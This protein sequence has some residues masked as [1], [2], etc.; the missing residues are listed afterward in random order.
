MLLML[1]CY[2]LVAMQEARQLFESPEV[3]DPESLKVCRVLGG[4]MSQAGN[5]SWVV[6]ACMQNTSYLQGRF[7]A[8][9]GSSE[10]TEFT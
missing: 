7:D 10:S 3:I 5:L 9:G 1:C 6:S 8:I 4:V 2:A